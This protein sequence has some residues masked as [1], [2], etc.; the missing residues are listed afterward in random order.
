MQS[1]IKTTMR[2]ILYIAILFILVCGFRQTTT[3]I[4]KETI[5]TKYCGEYLTTQI[6]ETSPKIYIYPETDSTILFYLDFKKE[7]TTTAF[8]SLYGQVKIKNDTGLFYT[9]RFKSSTANCKLTFVFSNQNLQ[10][11]TADNQYACGIDN[12]VIGHMDFERKSK[13]II[14]YFINNNNKKVYYKKTKPEVYYKNWPN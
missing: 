10:I 7:E 6:G 14:P 11:S 1:V 2:S 12:V 13:K 5:T 9:D 8:G 3:N 4:S